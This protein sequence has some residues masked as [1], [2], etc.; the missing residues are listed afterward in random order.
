MKEKTTYL[1]IHG[2][3]H[4]AWCWD[5]TIKEIEHLGHRAISI[6]LPGHGRDNTPRQSVTL[7]SYISAIV[8]CIETRKLSNVHLVGHSLAG[9]TLPSVIEQCGDV[10]S[11]VTLLAAIVLSEGQRVIDVIPED[12]RR[13]YFELADASPDRSV[14]FDLELARQ[15]FFSKLSD[16][17][18]NLYYSKLTPQPFDLYLEPLPVGPGGIQI[19]KR[20]ILCTED[21]AL[22][23]PLCENFARLLGVQPLIVNS[24]HDLM[25]SHPKVLAHLLVQ[26]IKEY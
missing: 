11:A 10:V 17:D 15:I 25:L 3:Y 20:Y 4:G 1:F 19:P 18:A 23:P 13:I 5:L 14:L 12:R 6:D 7:S 9:V 22:P 8:K 2:A 16:E 21:Q 24:G 26:E